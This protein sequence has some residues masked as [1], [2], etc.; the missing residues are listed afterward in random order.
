MNIIRKFLLSSRT[1][2]RG[3]SSS[4]RGGGPS[5][6]ATRAWYCQTTRMATSLFENA[7]NQHLFYLEKR[8][9]RPHRVR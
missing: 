9:I 4:H 6:C 3:D 5:G 8:T 1:A 2:L 7:K